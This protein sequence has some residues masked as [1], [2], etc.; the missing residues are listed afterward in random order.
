M[1]KH[2]V[3]R[4]VEVDVE[5]AKNLFIDIRSEK[6]FIIPEFCDWLNIPLG[7]YHSMLHRG[8]I[9]KKIFREKL[10]PKMSHYPLFDDA[11]M[12]GKD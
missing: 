2:V 3:S 10:R 5:A 9:S 7:T 6:G 1:A 8:K 11:F 4:S 12:I